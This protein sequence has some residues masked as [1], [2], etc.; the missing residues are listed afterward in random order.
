MED[1]IIYPAIS[2]IYFP[3]MVA[4]SSPGFKFL[5]S[6]KFKIYLW[7]KSHFTL[8]RKHKTILINTLIEELVWRS[9]FIYICSELGFTNIIIIIIGSLLFYLIHLDLSKKIIVLSEIE[10]LIFSF[11]L[12]I[13]FISTESILVVWLIHFMRNSYLQF[14]KSDKIKSA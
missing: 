3:F 12:Y 14:I 8:T 2:I 4:L 6:F 13:I 7:L 10:L 11:L 9:S 5:L 1:I